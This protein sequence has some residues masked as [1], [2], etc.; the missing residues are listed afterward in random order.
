MCG[1]L[2]DGLTVKTVNAAVG[3]ENPTAPAGNYSQHAVRWERSQDAEVTRCAPSPR[4]SHSVLSSP[5][6]TVQTSQHNYG[7]YCC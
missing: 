1:A 4:R 5:L 2:K 7:S 3:R 6:A